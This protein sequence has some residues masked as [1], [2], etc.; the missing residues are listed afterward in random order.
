MGNAA[1]TLLNHGLI[2]RKAQRAIQFFKKAWLNSYK[3][4]NTKLG[5][6]EKKMRKIYSSWWIIQILENLWKMCENIEMTNL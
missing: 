2:L 5:Q 1:I 4:M 6:K 3:D